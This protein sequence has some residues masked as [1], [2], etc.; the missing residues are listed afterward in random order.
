M[1]LMDGEIWVWCWVGVPRRSAAL[2]GGSGSFQG[3]CVT[4]QELG[5]EKER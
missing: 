1:D 4:K 5:N 3:R 2:P